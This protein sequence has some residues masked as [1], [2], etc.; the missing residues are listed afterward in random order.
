VKR[1]RRRF[2]LRPASEKDVE[3]LWEIQRTAIGPWVDATFGWDEAQQR[4]FFDEH[5]EPARFE[6]IQVAGEDAG[7]LSVEER[8]DHVYLGNLALLPAFQRQGIGAEVA[9]PV[10]E[11]AD[12]RGLPVRLQVLRSN[13]ARRFYE[14]LGFVLRGETETHFQLERPRRAALVGR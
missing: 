5:F 2:T 14:R 13:P 3:L 8:T 6:I 9:A 12:A 7:F 10:L 11:R 1:G 4:R